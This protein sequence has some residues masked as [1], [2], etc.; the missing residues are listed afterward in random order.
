[1][2]TLA[3]LLLLTLS[4]GCGD[5]DPTM[6]CETTVTC[7]DEKEMFCDDPV[8]TQFTDGTTLELRACTYA[9]YEHCFERTE[10][11]PSE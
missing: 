3:V 4:A 5:E 2:K 9:T 11:K 8:S 6:V 7:E 1:M 10:C